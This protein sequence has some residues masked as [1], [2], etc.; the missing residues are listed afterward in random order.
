[1]QRALHDR[2]GV[3]PQVS[4]FGSLEWVLATARPAIILTINQ[5]N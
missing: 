2:G 3:T 5:K 1:M 4:L